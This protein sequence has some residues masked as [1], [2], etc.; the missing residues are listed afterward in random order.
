[1]TYYRLMNLPWI[2]NYLK[3]KLSKNQLFVKTTITLLFLRKLQVR[4]F[5]SIPYFPNILYKIKNRE[6]G[7]YVW[8]EACILSLCPF[9]NIAN[10]VSTHVTISA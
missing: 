8:E 1:M 9:R 2:H 4:P 7:I 10:V 3:E 5:G 6:S